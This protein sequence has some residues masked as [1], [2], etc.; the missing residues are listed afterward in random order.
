[1]R[2][3]KCIIEFILDDGFSID[4]QELM[5][6]ENEILVGDGN[7]ILHSND[8]GDTVG[9]I[10]SVKNIQYLGLTNGEKPNP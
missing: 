2:R 6:L 1:M 4:E 8:I 7:L 10:K 9:V 3:I 5:W